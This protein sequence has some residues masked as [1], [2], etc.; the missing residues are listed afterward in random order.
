MPFDDLPPEQ[1]PQF[2]RLQDIP[3]AV[4]MH[5]GLPHPRWD[6]VWDHVEENVAAEERDAAYWILVYQ[7]LDKMAS[8]L[9]GN[10]EIHI[11]PNFLILA[12]IPDDEAMSMLRFVE[13]SLARI[14]E[15][16][17][18]PQE[19]AVGPYVV[20]VFGD[21]DDFARYIAPFY[22]PEGEF[23]MPGGVFLNAGYSHVAIQETHTYGMQHT[24]THE[25]A[26]NVLMFYPLP[27]WLNEGLVQVLTEFL[28]GGHVEPLDSRMAR[29]HRL[30]WNRGNIQD[31]WS[32]RSFT[33]PGDASRLSYELAVVA[34]RNLAVGGAGF[35]DFVRA[36]NMDD[37]GESAAREFMRCSLADA[38]TGLLGE[39]PWAPDPEKWDRED[40]AESS[41]RPG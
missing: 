2:V 28:I 39:G 25:L 6:I 37:A 19:Y 9:G 3:E 26:H 5:E 22:E 41:S 35:R 36:A 40:E 33:M 23:M 12:A 38:V 7:W 20:L 34:V 11:S 18:E 1:W 30:F 31:F 32:G 14:I 17:G 4:E 27:A 8:H 24:L 16:L 15:V 29:K 13:R 10:Y 21:G